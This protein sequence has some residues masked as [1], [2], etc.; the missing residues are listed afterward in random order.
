M[1]WRGGYRGRGC[2]PNTK[3]AELRFDFAHRPEEFEGKLRPCVYDLSSAVEEFRRRIHEALVRQ[4]LLD[5]TENVHIF[6][7]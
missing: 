4:S 7:V 1:K 2:C 6:K 5:N 3:K